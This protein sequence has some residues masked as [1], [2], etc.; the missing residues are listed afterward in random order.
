MNQFA[1]ASLLVAFFTQGQC[2]DDVPTHDQWSAGDCASCH[3]DDPPD[4][5]T[6]TR[7]DVQHGRAPGATPDRCV[8]CH[9]S[10]D[11]TTCHQLSPTSH[12]PG[13]VRPGAQGP[14]HQL[15]A[16]LGRVRP[17]A[18]ATCHDPLTEHCTACHELTE[19]W[20]WQQAADETLAPWGALLGVQ[21]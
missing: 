10:E 14:E 4:A 1:T 18:C 20:P 17:S 16:T 15:H 5:H 8:S 6:Q 7:W 21:P 2:V 3:E 12:T 19:V 13:F 11:C 9:P